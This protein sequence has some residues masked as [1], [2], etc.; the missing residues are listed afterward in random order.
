[1]TNITDQ[2]GY[3]E[4]VN[5]GPTKGAAFPVTI[6][7]TQCNALSDTGASDNCTSPEYYKKTHASM[8]K[9]VFFTFASREPL[10]PLGTVKCSFSIG[11]HSFE[12]YFYYLQELNLDFSFWTLIL[13]K[14]S[15][16]FEMVR[17]R[18]RIT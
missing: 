18:S 11:S 3:V 6:A 2:T 4:A 17:H 13:Y 5:I 14:T 7:G 12:F 9:Q 15:Y 1:M 10:S 8:N 16:W